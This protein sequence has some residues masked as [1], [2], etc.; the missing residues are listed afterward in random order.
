[1]AKEPIRGLRADAVYRAPSGRLCRWVPSQDRQRHV[2][3][4]AVFVYLDQGPA[5]RHQ[6]AAGWAEGFHL[7]PANYGLLREEGMR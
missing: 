4:Y 2:R 7:T 6:E 1:M 5:P 3:S